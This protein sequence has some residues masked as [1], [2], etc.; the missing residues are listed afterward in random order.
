MESVAESEK[1]RGTGNPG[2]EIEERLFGKYITC[3]LFTGWV[4]D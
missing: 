1:P 2:T 3:V 4:F